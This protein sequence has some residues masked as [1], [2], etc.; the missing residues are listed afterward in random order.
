MPAVQTRGV[1]IQLLRGV[2]G[3]ASWLVESV[4]NNLGLLKFSW[5]GR[6]QRLS[7]SE[8][9]PRAASNGQG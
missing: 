5:V 7:E 4:Y 2:T 1:L 3:V 9:S 8:I 6:G